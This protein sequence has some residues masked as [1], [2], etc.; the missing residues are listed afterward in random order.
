MDEDVPAAFFRLNKSE[1]L[2]V[3]NHFF[4]AS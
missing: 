1:A 4:P 3:L 2:L